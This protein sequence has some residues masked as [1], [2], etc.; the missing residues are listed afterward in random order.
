MGR[1]RRASAAVSQ[2][3]AW[4]VIFRLMQLNNPRESRV[5]QYT[6]KLVLVPL[7]PL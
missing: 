6:A 5:L 7:L 3:F 4:M 1:Q 2:G